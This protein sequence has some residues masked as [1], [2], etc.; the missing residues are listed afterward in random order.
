MF[1]P[2]ALL[3][4]HVQPFA[5][6]YEHFEE[7]AGSRFYHNSRTKAPCSIGLRDLKPR[8]SLSLLIQVAENTAN[9]V[10]GRGKSGWYYLVDNVWAKF[11]GYEIA[12]DTT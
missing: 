4:L 10:L 3:F 11:E 5:G 2:G 7:A 12:R 1:R 9:A 8:Q 6:C